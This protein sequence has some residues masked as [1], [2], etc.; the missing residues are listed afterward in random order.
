MGGKEGKPHLSDADLVASIDG[1][2]AGERQTRLTA[3]LSTCAAC[4]Q[5][6]EEFRSLGDRIRERYPLVDDPDARAKIIAMTSG[7]EQQTAQA[8]DPE[9]RTGW[10]GRLVRR[11][12]RR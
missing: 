6:L 12:P 11:L 1:A 4:R 9:D 7:N 5:R 8:A 10:F 3:H 2:L